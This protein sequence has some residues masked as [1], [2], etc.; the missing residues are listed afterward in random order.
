MLVCSLPSVRQGVELPN[1][2]IEAI[3]L[4]VIQITVFFLLVVDTSFG[5]RAQSLPIPMKV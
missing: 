3:D 1:S 4:Y 2:M 5:T